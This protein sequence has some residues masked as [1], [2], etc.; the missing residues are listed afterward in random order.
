MNE[1]QKEAEIKEQQ[2][3]SRESLKADIL[4]ESEMS[5]AEQRKVNWGILMT[6]VKYIWPKASHS[7]PARLIVG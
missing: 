5:K 7:M 3:K 4:Q 1:L 2:K 6:L